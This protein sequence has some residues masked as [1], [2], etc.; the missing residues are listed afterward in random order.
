[1]YIYYICAMY[2]VHVHLLIKILYISRR[3]SIFFGLQYYNQNTDRLSEVLY[4]MDGRIKIKINK[5]CL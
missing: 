5:L 2:N 3:F 4:R 1:M